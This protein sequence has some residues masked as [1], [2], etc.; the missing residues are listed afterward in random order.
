MYMCLS[1]LLN[2]L[3]AVLCDAS[4]YN[5]DDIEMM[6]KLSFVGLGF[7]LVLFVFLVANAKYRLFAVPN[8]FLFVLLIYT[9]HF[10]VLG[11]VSLFW[12]TFESLTAIF[13]AIVPVS[14]FLCLRFFS[15]Q[16]SR[17][18]AIKATLAVFALG[19]TMT[20]ILIVG[21]KI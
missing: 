9:S 11:L 2:G 14:Y 16:C 10:I 12:D 19:L 5:F 15:R 4:M 13:F 7:S 18:K 1:F 6:V 3:L 8:F 20:A 21:E 17:T